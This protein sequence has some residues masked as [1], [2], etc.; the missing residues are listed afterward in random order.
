MI[1]MWYNQVNKCTRDAFT[2]RCVTKALGGASMDKIVTQSP[3]CGIYKI[4]NL[5]NGMSY[6]GQSRRIAMRFREHKS[7]ER[8]QHN[9]FIHN[10]I[11]KYGIDNFTFEVIEECSVDQLNALEIKYIANYSSLKPNGYNLNKGGNS[12]KDISDETR[13]R[14]SL[15]KQGE[16]HNYYGTHRSEITKHRISTSKS[17]PVN[18]YTI[19]GRYIETFESTSIATAK[20]GVNLRS[21]HIME[22]CKGNRRLAHGF[23]WRLSDHETGNISPARNRAPVPDSQKI[24]LSICHEKPVSQFTKSGVY[25]ATF[26]SAKKAGEATETNWKVISACRTGK[27]KSAGGFVWRYAA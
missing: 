17:N 20:L 1:R 21:S 4:T 2:S 24:T 18:Q 3:V 23:Q 26:D 6:I 9:Y 8:K 12:R 11:N 13:M 25:I 14:M 5:V 10:A 22:C 7:G 19:D 27:K 16:K 15:S